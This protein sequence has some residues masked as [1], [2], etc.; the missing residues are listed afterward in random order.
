MQCK[1]RT[2]SS[3]IKTKLCHYS[4]PGHHALFLKRM[5]PPYGTRKKGSLGLCE[6]FR[7]LL[8]IVTTSI[9]SSSSAWGASVSCIDTVCHRECEE[10]PRYPGSGLLAD[11]EIKVVRGIQSSRTCLETWWTWT[12]TT[13]SEPTPASLRYT[14]KVYF[15]PRPTMGPLRKYNRSRE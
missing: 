7:A 6:T 11:C 9:L 2:V 4:Q 14:N 12:W 8:I 5:I 1:W 3:L 13:L 10:L 15:E